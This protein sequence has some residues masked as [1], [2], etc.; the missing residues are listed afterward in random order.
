MQYPVNDLSAENQAQAVSLELRV[1][2]QEAEVV[3]RLIE[4][5]GQR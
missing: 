3:R 4:E 1:E 5:E 2:H